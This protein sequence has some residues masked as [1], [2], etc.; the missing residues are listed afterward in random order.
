VSS[1]TEVFDLHADGEPPSDPWALA[2]LWLPPDEEPERPR[3]TLATVGQDGYPAARTVLLTAFD[4][5]GFAFHTAA[6]SRKTV[7]LAALPR[8]ALVLLW[9]GFDRQLTVRGDVVADSPASVA[10]AWTSRSDYLRRLAW[11]N[12]DELAALPLGERQDRW[13]DFAA[14]PPPPG[15]ADSWVGY[16]LLPREITFWAAHPDTASR[17]LRYDRG[18]EGWR[19]TYLAG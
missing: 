11:L 1:A 2:R 10:A 12:T 15:P 5:T 16:R 7:E 18:D 19:S 9:P 3:A 6:G 13:A 17:R 8:A 4:P 14:Q